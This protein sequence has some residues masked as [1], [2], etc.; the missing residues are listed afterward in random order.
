MAREHARSALLMLLD[1]H[2]SAGG[3]REELLQ[4]FKSFLDQK[5]AGPSWPRSLLFDLAGICSEIIKPK[6]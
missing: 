4:K 3:R 6:P 1:I 2:G 5:G